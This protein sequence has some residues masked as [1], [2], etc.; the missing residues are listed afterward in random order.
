MHNWERNTLFPLYCNVQVNLITCS[1][2]F[3][4]Y[5]AVCKQLSLA[6]IYLYNGSNFNS[7]QSGIWYNVDGAAKGDRNS[8]TAMAHC[9]PGPQFGLSEIPAAC[10]IHAA[11][12]FASLSNISDS[13][14]SSATTRH[15]ML[16]LPLFINVHVC[17]Q[18]NSNLSWIQSRNLSHP[19]SLSLSKLA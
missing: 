8:C 14:D 1:Y 15:S 7:Q 10:R 17:Q 19:L 6:V 11:Q 5:L 2:L 12:I 16:H 13:W 4:I 18:P 9:Y 3:T